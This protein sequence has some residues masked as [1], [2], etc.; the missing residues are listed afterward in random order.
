MLFSWITLPDISFDNV[1]FWTFLAIAN[2]FHLSLS[3]LWMILCLLLS[4]KNYEMSKSSLS[5]T[6]DLKVGH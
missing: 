1:Q 4:L 2:V 3:S 6:F 5:S